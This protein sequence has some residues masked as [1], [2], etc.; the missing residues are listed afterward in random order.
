MTGP[1]PH[2]RTGPAHGLV[3]IIT[4]F[5]RWDNSRRAF[6]LRRLGLGGRKGAA[7]IVLSLKPEPEQGV[8]FTAAPRPEVCMP[9][10]GR[11]WIDD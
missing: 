4:T 2:N 5:A 6:L 9:S 3:I 7:A 8:R 10:R 1:K 11:V